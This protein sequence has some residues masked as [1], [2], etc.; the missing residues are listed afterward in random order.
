MASP[1]WSQRSACT[2]ALSKQTTLQSLYHLF[3]SFLCRAGY[4][5][6]SQPTFTNMQFSFVT[7]F[8]LVAAAMASS[9]G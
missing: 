4:S 5:F 2:F 8:A 3:L 6:L 7:L 9:D 1:V